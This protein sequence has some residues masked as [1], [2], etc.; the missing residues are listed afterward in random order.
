MHVNMLTN[1]KGVNELSKNS[2]EW[3]N[4]R[5]F[6]YILVILDFWFYRTIQMQILYFF[7][8]K[9]LLLLEVEGVTKLFAKNI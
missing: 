4:F 1:K 2:C 6:L 8:Q 7:L 3:L 9:S 5:K